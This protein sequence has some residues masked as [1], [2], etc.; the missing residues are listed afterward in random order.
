MRR[1]QPAG[2]GVKMEKSSQGMRGP[3]DAEKDHR[4]ITSKEMEI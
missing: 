1:T 4:P 3:L 2:M